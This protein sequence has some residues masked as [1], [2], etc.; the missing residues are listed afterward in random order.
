M[1]NPYDLDLD[2]EDMENES[3]ELGL[4][5]EDMEVEPYDLGNDPETAAIIFAEETGVDPESEFVVVNEILEGH[6]IEL[7]RGNLFSCFENMEY[8]EE[9]AQLVLIEAEYFDSIEKHTI[10]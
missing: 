10:N 4:N 9:S 6:Y 5:N 7:F 2:D 3:Y 1:I 8:T